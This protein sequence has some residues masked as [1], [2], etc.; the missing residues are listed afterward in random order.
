MPT[1][2]VSAGG[3]RGTQET[4][5]DVNTGLVN[6]ILTIAN[7]QIQG[8]VA[9][10][11]SKDFIQ[12]KARVAQGE[13]LRDVQQSSGIMNKI[14]GEGATVQGARAQTVLQASDAHTLNMQQNMHKF[15]DQPTE[16][17]I[18]AQEEYVTENLLTGDPD[19]DALIT[20]AASE[21]ISKAT[22]IHAQQHAMYI[23]E[24]NRIE[25]ENT[26]MTSSELL[27]STL[28]DE[29]I[30]TANKIKQ[31]HSTAERLTQLPNQSDEAYRKSIAN[32]VLTELK[33]DHSELYKA[34][35]TGE[36][37]IDGQV[38]QT[39]TP[40]QFDAATTSSLKEEFSKHQARVDTDL[41]MQQGQLRSEVQNTFLNPT[42]TNTEA[43]EAL[44]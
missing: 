15:K 35:T 16:V 11:K 40:I 3:S 36:L 26:G 20:L 8:E 31:A 2:L 19:A 25:F 29:T 18:A 43:E 38:V 34:A 41:R 21:S 42:A 14:F 7:R 5:S 32:I 13:S 1:S 4:G 27:S 44:R 10:Q 39:N 37:V 22:G 23:Q 24:K 12:G 28:K 17:F 9:K 6:N 33:N 30:S